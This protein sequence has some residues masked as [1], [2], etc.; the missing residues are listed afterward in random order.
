MKF[1]DLSAKYKREIDAFV[2]W[3][4]SHKQVRLKGA[5]A[6]VVLLSNVIS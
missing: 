3:L 2:A 4:S 1:P 6:A 5:I